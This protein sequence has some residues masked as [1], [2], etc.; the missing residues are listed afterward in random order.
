MVLMEQVL[1]VWLHYALFEQSNIFHEVS[2]E[3]LF[4]RYLTEYLEE[5]KQAIDGN[6][7]NFLLLVIGIGR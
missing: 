7:D 5:K 2:I 1:N 4:V 6:D 3:W